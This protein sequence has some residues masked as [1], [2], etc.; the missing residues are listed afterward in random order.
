MQLTTRDSNILK[1]RCKPPSGQPPPQHGSRGSAEC[2]A[3]WLPCARTCMRC[4]WLRQSPRVGWPPYQAGNSHHAG[5]CGSDRTTPAMMRVCGLPSP[6][7]IH[8]LQHQ[9]GAWHVAGV[10]HLLE[11]VVSREKPLKVEKSVPGIT[12]KRLGSP[13]TPW[14]RFDR[15]AIEMPLPDPQRRPPS[16]SPGALRQAWRR[17]QV[18]RDAQHVADGS[19]CFGNLASVAC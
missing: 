19:N 12:T 7:T 1:L 10:G 14:T 15:K 17:S 18:Q 9:K 3:R 5:E 2:P 11:S 8:Q 4:R 16:S 6:Y 13:Q